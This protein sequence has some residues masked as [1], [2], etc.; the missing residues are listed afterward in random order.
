LFSRNVGQS[1]RFQ[2]SRLAPAFET[3]AGDAPVVLITL[4]DRLLAAIRKTH[5]NSGGGS[6]TAGGSDR[7]EER[8]QIQNRAFLVTGI[9]R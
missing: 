7:R 1:A 5:R 8:W 6:S 4:N 2:Y 3:S 9:T